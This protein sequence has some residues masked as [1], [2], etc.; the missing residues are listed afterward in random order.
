MTDSNPEADSLESIGWIRPT[1]IKEPTLFPQPTAN[2]LSEAGVTARD[3]DVWHARGWL[4]FK[5]DSKTE[6]DAPDRAE[7]TFIRD[8]ANSGLGAIVIDKLLSGLKRPYRYN[9]DRIAFSFKFGWV[10]LDERWYEPDWNE[11]VELIQENFDSWCDTLSEEDLRAYRD[12]IQDRL[13][14]CGLEGDGR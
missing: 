11:I 14:S 5:S 8:L 4:S 12:V 9:A 10:E 2:V 6:L 1:R 3:M 13:G 7:L